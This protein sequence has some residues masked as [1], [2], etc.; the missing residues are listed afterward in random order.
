MVLPKILK[1]IFINY[2]IIPKCFIQTIDEA[3]NK[4]SD[5]RSKIGAYQNRL[6]STM[7]SLLVK[8]ENLSA[9]LSE[10]RDADIA[11]EA[12]ELT[13]QQILQQSS[14]TLLAQA[15]SNPSV[16]LKLLS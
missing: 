7:D 12:A 9:S 4:V 8:S 3:L 16:A 6:E 13:K 14:A 15:N 1:Q 10:L 5:A 11:K 2:E